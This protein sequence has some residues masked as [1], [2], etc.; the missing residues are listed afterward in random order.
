[1]ESLINES[2]V[3]ARLNERAE[4]AAGYYFKK[5]REHMELME[6]QSLLSKT[7]SITPYDYYALG[8]QLEGFE[9]YKAMCSSE[10]M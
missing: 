5:Y 9:A 2:A 8:K 1:M 6:S 7:R 3:T 4:E 10:H